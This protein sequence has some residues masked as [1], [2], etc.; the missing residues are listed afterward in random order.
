MKKALL[1]LAL[2]TLVIASCDRLGDFKKDLP[3]VSSPGDARVCCES[4]GYGSRMVKCCRTYEWSTASRCKTPPEL[5][6][7]GK[8]IVAD[9]YC[10]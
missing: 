4:F 3:A 7:G 1:A 5:V 6:G 9:S 8:A 2:L 10:K